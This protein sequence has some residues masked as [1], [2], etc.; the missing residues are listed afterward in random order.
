M[1]KAAA[2]VLSAALST[3]AFGQGVKT[4]KAQ[5]SWPASLTIQDHFRI[6][7][8]NIEKV[9]GG[10]VKVEVMAAGQ[11][12]PAFEVLDATNRK[13]LDGYHSIS[14]YW[15]GKSPTAAL[16]SGPPGGPFGMDH[17]DYLGWMYVGGGLE[18]W[19]EFYQ[20][21]L[22]LNVIVWPAQ[23]SSPQAFGW[24]KKPLKS[25]ADMKGMKCRQTGLNA[26]VYAKLGQAVVNMPGGEILPA[27]QRGVI[28]CAEW[29]G[30]VEDL[31]LG[32]HQVFKYHYT[33][34]MHE[35]NSIGEF[36]LNLDV[37]KGL[38]PIQQ[39]AITI[40]VKEAYISWIT[41]WQK[42]NADAIEEMLKKHGVQILRTPP[43]I[44]LASLK[45]WDE[46]AAENS[47][48]SPTFKKVYASQREY[49][50][51]VVPAKRYMFPPYSFAAN[52]YWPEEKRGASAKKAGAG[53]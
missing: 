42:Q 16:F 36:G 53:K 48:K 43:D 46:V 35:N 52:Y 33:P 10:A 6:I 7:A 3:G 23:P 41:K 18:M 22:K 9:T 1:R 24:F 2:L 4:L 8:S 39:D 50:S 25:V 13:V 5:G 44:L 34:G 21:E 47:A 30:G 28:D 45:A 15:V 17:M 11:I 40:A 32:L 49:A 27:A 51:K 31:R 12:V 14:Y 37:F 20:Q 38:T 19:R 26:E 29:V